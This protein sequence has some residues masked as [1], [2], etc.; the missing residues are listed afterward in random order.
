MAVRSA[1]QLITKFAET[2]AFGDLA[3]SLGQTGRRGKR[4]GNGLTVHPCVSVDSRAVAGVTGPMA[5]PVRIAA[6]D[7][8]SRHRTGPHVAQVGDLPLNAGATNAPL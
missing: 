4:L 5:V 3:L 2:L 7:T 6:T 8:G 1:M